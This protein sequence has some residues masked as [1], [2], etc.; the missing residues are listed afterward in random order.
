PAVNVKETDKAYEIT[1]AAPGLD[2]NDFKIDVNGSLITISAE[3]E[4]S[5]EEKEEGYTR[6]EYN[7]SSFS[8]S[9]SLPEDTLSDKIDANYVHGELKLMLPKKEGATKTHHMKISVH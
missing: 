9:F 3:R 8:R 7:Y 5:D 2:K 4:K 1:M 6:K